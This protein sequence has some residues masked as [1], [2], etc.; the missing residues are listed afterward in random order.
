VCYHVSGYL[1][2]TLLTRDPPTEE[3][4]EKKKHLWI[5]GHTDLCVLIQNNS[6]LRL[7]VLYAHQ[8]LSVFPLCVIDWELLIVA[9]NLS[10]DSQP[11]AGLQVLSP[12]GE[13]RYIRHYPEH[14]IVNIGDSLEFL[15]GGLL[16][17]VPHRGMPR[18]ASHVF[19]FKFH[20]NPSDGTSERPAPVCTSFIEITARY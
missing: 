6:S 16:K 12:D 18:Y 15:T 9:S 5:P 7:T 13:W 10:T 14:I 4:R 2:L 1:H 11:I 20:S 3:D 17:A 8:W 19:K